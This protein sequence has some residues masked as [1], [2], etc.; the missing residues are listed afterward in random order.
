MT[1]DLQKSDLQKIKSFPN[2]FEAEKS[3]LCCIL[4]DGEAAGEILSVT[5]EDILYNERHQRI[6]NAAAALFNSR[7]AVDIIS[8]NDKLE[9]EKKTDINMLS[10]LN[11]LTAYLPSAANFRQYIKILERDM[12]HRRIITACNN[13]IEMAYTSENERA[14]LEEAIKNMMAIS[15]GIERGELLPISQAS[16]DLMERVNMMCQDK[17]SFKGV[18]TYFPVFDRVTNGLQKGDLIILAARPSVGKTSFALNIV[19]NMVAKSRKDIVVAIFSL[20]MPSMHLA[21]RILSANTDIQM[22]AISKG[23]LN[24]GQMTQLW[25]AHG[26]LAESKVFVDDTALQTPGSIITKCN[27]LKAKQNNQLDLVIIDY[28]QLMEADTNKRQSNKNQEVAD[29]TRR[30]KLLARDLDC[31]VIV[32]SQMS[33]GIESRD[34]K[35]PKLSDLRESGAIE[36]DAD[37]V[38]FLSRED[39]ADKGKPSYNIILDI[40]KHRNGALAEIRYNWESENVRFSESDDQRI[41]R[42]FAP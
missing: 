22:R 32:L 3:L 39:E 16:Q 38:M 25:S 7:Q 40:A 17:S 12:I 13:I 42:D 23:E 8:V 24:P 41:N 33:R 21:Q 10:Y 31:P 28:L 27:K 14:T 30:M 19:S 5:S 2:N 29:I 1:N 34:D 15:S 20:E 11:E 35:I 26:E 36:Q 6:F 9:K 18:P 37:I 4:I